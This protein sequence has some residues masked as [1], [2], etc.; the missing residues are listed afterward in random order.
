MY[1]LFVLGC[2]CGNVGCVCVLVAW[3]S[4]PC[5]SKGVSFPPMLLC[6]FVYVVGI[7]ARLRLAD[8]CCVV[9][10]LIT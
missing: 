7:V 6:V 8:T 9:G 1:L 2:V 10:R 3:L 4:N 5:V